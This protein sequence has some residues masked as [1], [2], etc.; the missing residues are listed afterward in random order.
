VA[1][2]PVG[3]F[4]ALVAIPRGFADAATVIG[5][6]FLVGAGL[7]VVDKTGALRE[8][9]AWLIGRLHGRPHLV[10]PIVGLAFAAG[11]VVEGMAE[12]IIP[13][14][15]MLLIVTDTLGYPPITAAAMSIGAAAVGGAFSP[16]NPFQVGI[17]QKL[18]GLP[19][20]SGW[21]LRLVFMGPA[22]AIWMWGTE[23]MTR[24]TA[25]GGPKRAAGAARPALSARAGVLLAM[26]LA[27]IVA[28][29]IGVVR[30]GW[31]FEQ[32]A[33]VFLLLGLVA[34]VAGGL[35]V[36]GT[37][38][39]LAEGFRGMAYSGMLIGFARAIY[40]V[41]DE[42]HVIDTIVYSL[43]L[44]LSGLPRVMAGLGM[45]AAQAV[46]HVPVPSTSGQAVLSM[47]I[48]VPLGDLLG[49]SGQITV[50]A[51]QFGGGLCELLTPTNGALMAVLA[52]ARVDYREWVRFAAPLYLALMLAGAVALMAAMSLGI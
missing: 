39:S 32:M 7:T 16:M 43:F 48:L 50:L 51:Y 6:V 34:G 9:V 15:P 42:A 4:A 41:L 46:L 23:R 37:M 10:V 35:G 18:A 38:D 52:A 26:V 1:A 27:A 22:I 8:G 40:V 2:A 20:L 12:E 44:P 47:P 29:V 24:R 49:L 36:G 30:F 3:P 28:Y 14:V 45:M 19:L 17:A 11:G 31:D 33:A 5:F 13:L 25:E 21:G